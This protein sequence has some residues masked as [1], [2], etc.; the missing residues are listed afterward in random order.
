MSD[1]ITVYAAPEEYFNLSLT[2]EEA[3]LLFSAFQEKI[4][5]GNEIIR[6]FQT[7]RNYVELHVSR[8]ELA[9]RKILPLVKLINSIEEI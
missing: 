1:S 6:L 5:M 4:Y 3:K 7:D 9:E 8:I 2:R